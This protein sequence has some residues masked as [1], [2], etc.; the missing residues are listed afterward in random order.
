MR[1]IWLIAGA[2]ATA[3]ACEATPPVGGNATLETGQTIA[4]RLYT[5]CGVRSVEVNGRTFFAQP[6]LDDGNGNPPHDWGNPYDD[7]SLTLVDQHTA[8][9]QDSTGNT[10]RFSDRPAGPTPTRLI[11]S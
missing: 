11:C 1:L 6:P 5:H 4:Y 10:A 9:F 7:G 2:A 8:V 3:M